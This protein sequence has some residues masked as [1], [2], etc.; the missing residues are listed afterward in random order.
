MRNTRLKAQTSVPATKTAKSAQPPKVEL[1]FAKQVHAAVNKVRENPHSILP[2]L[3]TQ[4]SHVDGDDVLQVP[5]RDP[6]Q[7]EEGKKAVS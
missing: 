7:L 6:I 1:P 2:H 4:M 5:G 3:Q